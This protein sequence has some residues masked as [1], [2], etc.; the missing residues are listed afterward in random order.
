MKTPDELRERLLRDA[1][2]I[3]DM[4]YVLATGRDTFG[5]FDD[6]EIMP[7]T[8]ILMAWFRALVEIAKTAQTRVN[9]TDRYDS[10]DTKKAVDAVMS[11]VMNGKISV[12]DGKMLIDFMAAKINAVEL[13]H[14][15]ERLDQAGMNLQNMLNIEL[16]PNVATKEDESP[17]LQ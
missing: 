3:L 15:K 12:Q 1:D 16:S 7:N 14:L 10:S 17:T 11:D 6:L 2:E 8:K 13:I 4:V 9:L 5:T